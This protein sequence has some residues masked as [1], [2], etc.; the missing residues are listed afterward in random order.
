MKKTIIG[1]IA[2]ISIGGYF[3]FIKLIQHEDK[4]IICNQEAKLC[5]DGTYVGREVTNNCEFAK[6]PGTTM[7]HLDDNYEKPQI[8]QL[9]PNIISMED[10][11][12]QGGE[13]F[14]ILGETTYSGELIGT[15]EGLRC[16]CACRVE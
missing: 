12:A 4:L 2:I 16:P 9:P 13:I 7:P 8:I 6:C 10:C 5:L 14:N 15:I 11:K 3:L 1:I